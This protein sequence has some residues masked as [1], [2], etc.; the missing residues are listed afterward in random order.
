MMILSA[1]TSNQIRIEHVASSGSLIRLSARQIKKEG[2]VRQK[3]VAANFM[4]RPNLFEAKPTRATLVRYRAI[5]KSVTDHPSSPL[6]RRLDE[7][8]NMI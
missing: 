1:A 5:H 2:S 4:Q 3:A 8:R 7:L 6:Q